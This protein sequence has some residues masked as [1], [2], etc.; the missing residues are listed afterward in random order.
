MDA[1]QSMS[2][3]PSALSF[4]QI[5]DLHIL[6][7]YQSSNVAVA[8]KQFLTSTN[9]S[10]KPQIIKTEKKMNKHFLLFTTTA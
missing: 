5:F 1:F 7:Y 3:E 9:A 2:F 6:L 10:K 8:E 4:H